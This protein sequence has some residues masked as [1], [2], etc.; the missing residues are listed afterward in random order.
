MPRALPR[1]ASLRAR[2]WDALVLGGALS[3][4]AAAVRLGRA[5]LRVCVVEE[6]TAARQPGFLREPFFLPGLAGEGPLDQALRSLG[7]PPIERRDLVID[8]VAFQ[9]LL[10]SARV[11]VGRADLLASEL[12]SWGLAKPEDA[13]AFVAAIA[14]AG[15]AAERRFEALEWI[16]RGGLRGLARATREAEPMPALPD[17]LTAPEPALAPLI[18]AWT[19]AWAGPASHALPPEALARLLAAPLAGGASFARPDSGL[20]SLLVRRIE[21]LHGEF[22]TLAGPFRL[23]ELG[24]DPGLARI[25]QDD[26]WLGRAL[27]VNAPA[28]Q[29]RAALR[30]FGQE[31]P[32][33]LNGP[34]PA[35]RE[36][37]LHARALREAVPEPLARRAVLA[38]AASGFGSAAWPLT[39]RQEASARGPQFV[40]LVASAVFPADH[41]LAIAEDTLASGLGALLPF[42]GS[43]VRRANPL[44]A[45]LWD[46]DGARFE[47]A[48][49]S[50]PHGLEL[51][52][53][54]R[55]VYRLAREHVAALGSEGEIL[56]GLRAGDAILADLS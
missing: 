48:P 10:P 13:L 5:G 3:G 29:L 39:L 35:A 9:V 33:W 1:S 15:R 43:R 11:D 32:R 53:G 19:Q 21:S 17:T 25:A 16:R 54:R 23:V 12:V 34:A 50:W 42:A 41:D 31:A 8:P 56:L 22:R 55:A 38:R 37:R 2:R 49:G 47:A 30:E 51:R 18:A 27:I 14:E 40:E 20:R 7:L 46:D 6:E 26:V 28:V 44:P 4:L 45:P 52:I 36:V 24:E